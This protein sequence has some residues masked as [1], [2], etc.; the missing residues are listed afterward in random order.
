MQR[1][2]NSLSFEERSRCR[3]LG[4]LKLI[5]H[6]PF[7]EFTETAVTEL[8]CGCSLNFAAAQSSGN[9]PAIAAV[10]WR[11]RTQTQFLLLGSALLS[12]TVLEFPAIL[13]FHNLSPYVVDVSN[14][15]KEPL[16][17]IQLR[18]RSASIITVALESIFAM[19][20]M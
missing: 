8:F 16:S 3:A 1:S 6:N 20:S 19:P 12:S 7:V 10:V 2:S 14:T 5:H 17:S 11:C 15:C 18:M 13:L 9:R 4:I